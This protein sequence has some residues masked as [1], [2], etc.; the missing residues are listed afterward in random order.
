MTKRSRKR[1]SKRLVVVVV[2]LGL[3]GL[4]LGGIAALTLSPNRD[5]GQYM[6]DAQAYVEKGDF[7]AAL[8]QLRNAVKSEPDNRDARY[9]LAIVALR[10]GDPVSAEKEIKV[11]QERGLS[12]DRALPVLANAYLDQG[13][14]NDVIKTIPEASRSPE[15][16]STIRMLRG[17]AQLGM[18]DI[19]AA[20]ASF[21]SALAL[22]SQQTRAEIGLARIDA[23]RQDYAAADVRL[24][25][26]IARQ[27]SSEIAAEAL[28]LKAQV[29]RLDM[30]G[31]GA[32]L[33][34]SKV[35]DMI[36]SMLRARMERAEVY[37][38][39]KKDDL[40]AGDVG[41]VL[42]RNPTHPQAAHFQALIF[43]RKNDEDA[44]F[45]RL[46][47]QG[48]ALDRYAPSL[49]MMGQLQI[50]R[51]QLESAQT[52]LMAY[53]QVVPG[54]TDARLLLGNL[55]LRKD[56]PDQAIAVLK[57][58]PAA[59]DGGDIRVLRMLAS[60]SM[61]AGRE[62]E[63]GAWLDKA[64]M[65][66]NAPA[67]RNQP[68]VE[69]LSLSQ[70]DASIK[71]LDSAIEIDTK[72]TDSRVMLTLTHLRQ[73]RLDDAERLAKSLQA[74]IPD[75]PIPDNLLG[76][77][78]M[79]RGDGASAR[80]NF[81]NAVRKKNDFLPA[82][83]NIA[84]LDVAEGRLDDA[85]RQYMAILEQSPKNTDVMIAIAEL[86]LR[87]QQ[88]DDAEA[89][90]T[91]AV[92][93]D[94]TAV[95]P[96]VALVNFHL[97]QKYLEKAMTAALSL[98]QV[99]PSN[100]DA[101]DALGRVQMAR[102]E[103]D[104]AVETYRALVAEAPLAPVAHERLAQALVTLRDP[105][106]AKTAL[107]VGM[108]DNPDAPSLAAELTN[109]LQRTGETDAALTVAR[110]WQRRH[111]ALAAGDV[112]LANVLA[113]QGKYD[114]A[115]LSFAAALKKEPSTATM[116]AL[117]RTRMAAGNGDIA[118]NEL[119]Q[120][121]KERPRDVAARDTLTSIYIVQ[122]RY[123]LAVQ[124]SEELLKLQPSS[125]IVLNN[126][127]WLYNQ[128]KDARALDHAER[129][130]ALAPRAPLIM[131]T[132]G[133]ILISKGNMERGIPLLRQAYELSQK[134]PEIGYHLAVGLAKTS[135]AAEAK[136]LLETVLADP[137]SFD[138]KAEAR[139]LFESIAR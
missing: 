110:D 119:R 28:L 92:A 22:D 106:A 5:A 17:M 65:V 6:A 16:E 128:R 50:K 70:T 8:I 44:A 94:V 66:S 134:M 85:M 123:D 33:A 71:D 87:R 23:I 79:A 10:A 91:K 45:D 89:W 49:L 136:A 48:A 88:P 108:A 124:E 54:N 15:T 9:Q 139:K 47:R 61:R 101:M 41:Y 76:G 74:D 132:L 84:K 53:L 27:P 116:I 114:D 34:Y 127:A 105:A 32:I 56:L 126:L 13:K 131:D 14:L 77:I 99:A 31:D 63:A 103:V 67:A 20:E 59:A 135:R 25:Q 96:R 102:G 125:P 95:I 42:Q 122:K 97:S 104:S 1:R 12:E 113:Q 73:G 112:I 129:A 24:E 98:L 43:L 115:S 100:S 11:A 82:R 107:R 62:S 64:A 121:T 109:L 90:L 55:L 3:V 60:A 38:E 30:D 83:L 51:N 120:W 21:Q 68:P 4:G 78:G 80:R 52:N 72:A 7:S 130:Y 57:A 39:Q 36:P 133:Y 117:A 40:A 19:A 93:I 81:E 26:I 18:R 118:A 2:M 37:L 46:Q 58:M 69:R 35:I 138:D 29:R 137:R 86:S 75:S 111:P